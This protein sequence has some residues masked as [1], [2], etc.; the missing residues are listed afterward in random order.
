[1]YTYSFEKLEVWQL[2]RKLVKEIY[3]LTSGFPDPEKF[4]L[5]NQM[6]RAVISIASNLAEGTSRVG[7]KDKANY[8]Q[9]AYSSL[10]ELLNQLIL[11]EDLGFLDNSQLEN[12][13]I[14][15][16]EIA[17]KITA[18]RKAQLNKK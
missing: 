4:G 12:T 11:S 3:T 5:V 1:M 2:S 17:N 10:M 15:I 13:R 16:D 8:S 7:S 6:R 9:I 14:L 18:L